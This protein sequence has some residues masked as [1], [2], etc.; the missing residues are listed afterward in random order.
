MNILLEFIKKS[1]WSSV[2]P[3]SQNGQTHSNE[4]LEGVWPFSDIGAQ[5]VNRLKI[6]YKERS[7]NH[8]NYV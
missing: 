7:G 5:R 6:M 2:N 8:L 3:I 1:D 4:L